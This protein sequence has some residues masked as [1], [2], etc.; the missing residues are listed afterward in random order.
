PV[1]VRRLLA[2]LGAAGLVAARV[3]KSGG[4]GLLRD[5]DQITL[6]EVYRAVTPDGPLVT[7]LRQ[8]DRGCRV[9]TGVGDVLT[10][11]CEDVQQA[12]ATKPR[13]RSVGWLRDQALTISPSWARG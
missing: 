12:V 7:M 3:G 2:R 8:V 6:D 4:Y 9:S 1:V 11:I 10:G 5:P 13:Q